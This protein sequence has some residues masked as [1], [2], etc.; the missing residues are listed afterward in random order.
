MH[1]GY[2]LENL[3]NQTENIYLPG[4]DGVP[5]PTGVWSVYRSQLDGVQDLTNAGGQG[6]QGV[7][8]LY[9]NINQSKTFSFDC[10]D[11]TLALVSPFA[12]G[13]TVKNLFYPYDE[14]VL[15]N[16]TITLDLNGE[17]IASGCFSNLT[18]DAW[19]YKVYVPVDKFS[20]PAPTITKLSPS[21]DERITSSVQLGEQQSLPLAIYFSKNMSCNSVL[22]S[23][24]TNST[25]QDGSIPTIS[26][27]SCSML[28]AAGETS[29][30]GQ[31]AS[32][33]IFNATL[34]NVSHGVHALSMTNASA[35]DGTYTNA[36]D[37]FLFRL[38]A[39][40]NPLV[41]PQSGN[42]STALLHRDDSTGSLYIS[43]RAA[44]ADKFRYSRNWASTW[45]NW[46]DYTSE[47]VTL[48]DQSWSG[49][50]NQE[51]SG[52][53]VIVQYWSKL[54]G[55]S[56]HIQHG[57]LSATQKARRW[58][59][60]F[61]LGA[62]NSWG[63]DGGLAHSM[64]LSSSSSSNSSMWL[65]DLA[66]EYPTRTQINVW[67]MNPDGVPD[68]TMQFGDVDGDGVLDWL[69]PDALSSN[70]I[71]ITGGPSMPHM[72]WRIEV[73]DGDYR[74]QLIPAGNAWYQ[75]AL[76]ILLALV[77]LVSG[78]L[79][80][81]AFKQ[82]YYQVKFNQIG[83]A[84]S[85]GLLTRVKKGLAKLGPSKESNEKAAVIAAPVADPLAPKKTILIATMEYEIED[86]N[87][88][89]K[90]GG[91]GKMASLMGSSALEHQNLVWVIPCVGGI[92]YPV[93]QVAEPMVVTINEQEYLV[94]VQYH[95]IRNITFV[96][97]DAPVFRERSKADP[98]PARM[99]D[100]ES[101][102][103]Y[104]A[105]NACIAETINRFQPD[106]YHIND[107]HGAL[108]PLYLLPR[109]IPVCLSLHNAEFQGMWSLRSKGEMAEI[110]SVFNL[111]KETVKSYVQF[112]KVFN[113]LYAGA[114]Y[115]RQHQ[116]G[117]G[118]VG[119][120]KKY[121]TRAF[122]RYPIFWGLSEIGSLPNPDPDDMAEWNGTLKELKASE[123][124][125]NEE[126]EQRRGQLR[127]QAQQWAG[128]EVDSNAELFVFVGR[129]SLQKGVDLIA[130]IFPEIMDKHKNVQLICIG[131]TIDNHGK[132]AA[133]KLEK[134]M[135]RYPGRVYSKP[136][137]I[138]I[139]PFVFSGAEFA[140]MPS[141]DEPF[142]LVAVEFGRKGALCVGS[143]VGGLGQM[144]GWWFTIESTETK[145]LLRQFKSAIKSALASSQETRR[146]M[147]ARS[148]LQRFPVRQW[149][150]DLEVL[151]S[152]SIQAHGSV[153][154]GSTLN[155]LM[156][157]MMSGLIT[158]ISR[159]PP[160]GTLP[161]SPVGGS[162]AVPSPV[163]TAPQTAASSAFPSRAPS[164]A[165]SRPGSR[166]HSPAR[167]GRRNIP[168][169]LTIS[170]LS[171]AN[172]EA[173]SDPPSPTSASTP[174]TPAIPARFTRNKSSSALG[175]LLASRLDAL[176][177]LE[178]T[179]SN[180]SNGAGPSDSQRRE[181]QN[182]SAESDQQQR[183][184]S[185]EGTA[186]RMT[187]EPTTATTESSLNGMIRRNQSVLTL[188]TIVGD[189]K[190]FELQKVEP[191]FN[192]P[193]GEYYSAFG[194]MLEAHEGS[195]S[196]DKLCVEEYIRSSE[197]DWFAKFHDTKLG[198]K[199]R[200]T[201]QPLPSSTSSSFRVE[202][203]GAANEFNLAEDYQPPTGLKKIM[204]AK[205]GDWPIYAFFLA[206]GQILA[207]NSYQITLLTGQNGQSAEQVY[208]TSSVYLGASIFWWA[209]FRACKLYI[210]ISLAFFFYGAAFFVLGMIPY[211][212]SSTAITGMQYAAT[213]LYAVGSSSGFLFFTQ[214]FLT[215]GGNPVRSWMFR[216][217]T[218]QG[219]QQIYIAALWYWGSYASQLENADGTA[220]ITSSNRIVTCVTVPIAVLLWVICGILFHGLPDAYRS[221]PGYV[222]GFYR[223]LVRRKV[224]IWFL[225]VAVIQNYFLST[226]YGRSW[227]YLWSSN[228]APA[229]AVAVLAI[230]FFI[231]V[232]SAGLGVMAHLSKEHS[233]AL[234]LFAIGLGAPR[235]AQSLWG[236]S[237]VGLYLPWAANGVTGV[238]VGRGLWLWLG[239]LDA[240]Q[241]VGF[242][243][244]LLQ[245]LG[246]FHVSF[247]VFGAQVVGS[248]A[249]IAA[250]ASAPN[251]TGPGPVFPNLALDLRG[252]LENVWF[253]V[254]LALQL[255]ICVG[256]FRFFR[257]E[258]LFKP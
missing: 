20:E 194:D 219:T 135:K 7:W 108:A 208:I 255:L 242:G 151:Q 40:D 78:Y 253:W 256:F 206:F 145:H 37:R 258:Q 176:A 243:M 169:F 116:G 64:D 33:W 96:L 209:L 1:D 156:P 75:L 93:D 164:R 233:W 90:I 57:D 95:V 121:G 106:L 184:Q 67:G 188:D 84:A 207:A 131:P 254:P 49:T 39:G 229:W 72:A 24:S 28:D 115:L 214:N 201:T 59:H 142:G 81:W 191:F 38:G 70:N 237:G 45:S 217:C 91:L 225:V 17:T 107:Y 251:K 152:Q 8:I 232:W 244:I 236:T 130:D 83:I 73:N 122:K 192:D 58:P 204:L 18:L 100:I 211:T 203:A 162:T 53:H 16:S 26:N 69:H 182:S 14:Y 198:K 149:V 163:D 223:S 234:P 2:Q 42:Y 114:S 160:I 128:L 154:Q 54:A 82:S 227:N 133:L 196:S 30:T 216:A 221:K 112:D 134:I 228:V 124:V 148:L 235:W 185:D 74:Y 240:L 110:C 174:K 245:T 171:A 80:V 15:E 79:L 252:G 3:S 170:T 205:I 195:L 249:T 27:V 85:G 32:R 63:Y 92:D 132:F 144:P 51:W 120:S 22:E 48:E 94:S 138:P 166:A 155:L 50:S 35:V 88:K 153:R 146:L 248:L 4:S 189:R 247:T 199:P 230:S 99:D 178:R 197:K 137:F 98:Y 102:I 52:E 89:I 172:S 180:N 12:A 9:S 200:V 5:S 140:L 6:D 139:P 167:T 25:T 143:R 21:H 173:G 238:L 123:L 104:S 193:R 13:T 224:V 119:V 186:S 118:A 62:W 159:P 257:K 117:Y 222:S 55:S 68:K 36:T 183:K 246:R 113:M 23:L 31:P 220:L 97:L 202:D 103:Y 218:I 215:E 111:P 150:H 179:Q 177:E 161:N 168:A 34:E 29:Y 127:V 105:W 187:P 77:P 101:A 165:N 239:V 141:R 175:K 181:S 212:S 60:A 157:G 210:S 87:I 56:D 19:S 109:T 231:G 71:N 43:Q 250:R 213:A 76:F 44:G 65:F 46:T 11:E 158:P 10:Q 86:W 190:D 241:G 129:W 47:N 61:V 226:T 41:F 125:V 136:E 147:R 66:A 126:E